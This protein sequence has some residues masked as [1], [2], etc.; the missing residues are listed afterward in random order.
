MS[1]HSWIKPFYNIVV[2]LV[3]ERV[4]VCVEK[5]TFPYFIT[6]TWHLSLSSEPNGGWTDGAPLRY[7]EPWRQ[8]SITV[9]M[10]V[11]SNWGWYN[12]QSYYNYRSYLGSIKF[13]LLNLVG[14]LLILLL[15]DKIEGRKYL[16]MK[17]TV[18]ETAS[19]QLSR[20]KTEPLLPQVSSQQTK[21]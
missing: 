1:F 14:N 11:V 19:Q 12:S 6:D 8:T 17:G 20:P 13:N 9:A 10:P 3:K 2:A 15:C 4:V 18:T 7:V 5:N 16:S 21:T